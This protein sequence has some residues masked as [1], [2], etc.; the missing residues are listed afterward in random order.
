[1]I[2]KRGNRFS[3]EIVRKN[4]LPQIEYEIEASGKPSLVF[5]RA[6]QKLATEQAV[7]SVVR[8]PGEVELRRQQ[9]SRGWRDL[10]MEVARA[11]LIGARNDGTKAIA[12]LGVGT[13]MS[14][15]AKA[16]IVVVARIVG[17]PEINDSA[18]YRL[19]R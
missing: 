17:L 18:W 19:A 9:P 3:D 4:E 15:Q 5:R 16:R 8:L 6:D 7:L 10:H 14:T 13:L 12:T 1:M 11:A 2:P